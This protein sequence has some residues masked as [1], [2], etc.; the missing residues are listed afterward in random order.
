MRNQMQQ[1]KNQTQCAPK[2]AFGF[3]LVE[4]LV[5]IAIIALLLSIMIPALSLAK[6]AA[7]K[8][9]CGSNLHSIGTGLSIYQQNHFERLPPQYDRW[10]PVRQTYD[11]QYMEPWVSYVA[12]HKDEIS[13]GG[14]FKPLQLAY[15]W[16][17]QT[18]Q[19][20][21]VFYCKSQRKEGDN[22]PSTS[23]L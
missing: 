13:S 18:L 10:G 4:L 16:D 19:T 3:T 15:L 6:E 21:E 8:V 17:Q 14:N 23:G 20:P 2:Q 22:M 11:N 12:Y 5:V 1:V 9:V 7:N